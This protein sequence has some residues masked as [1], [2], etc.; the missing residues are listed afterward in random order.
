MAKSWSLDGSPGRLPDTHRPVPGASGRR[1]SLGGP[2]RGSG[3]LG[4]CWP[5]SVSGSVARGPRTRTDRA[6]DAPLRPRRPGGP[7]PHTDWAR[8]SPVHPRR[9]PAN[10]PPARIQC[11]P[12]ADPDP[13]DV[14]V[15]NRLCSRDSGCRLLPANGPHRHSAGQRRWRLIIVLVARASL[16]TV[17]AVPE[18]CRRQSGLAG[19][20]AGRPRRVGRVPGRGPPTDR[21]G[22]DG[23]PGRA[24]WSATSLLF[25]VRYPATRPVGR[26]ST[27][28]RR[29]STRSATTSGCPGH[30]CRPGRNEADDCFL[31]PGSPA[32]S[33]HGVRSARGYNPLDVARYRQFL[34]FVADVGEPQRAFSGNFTNPVMTDFPVKNRRLFD[35]LGV[36]WEVAPAD[37]PPAG[38]AGSGSSGTRRMRTP[39]VTTSSAAGCGN[40]AH[41]PVLQRAVDAAGVPRPRGRPRGGRGGRARAVEGH[42]PVADG[43]LAGWD[44]AADP[45]PAR[46]PAAAG[47]RRLPVRT[48]CT[49]NSTASRPGCS[50]SPTRGTPAGRA[51]ST[52]KRSRSGRPTTPSAECMVPK[53]AREVRVPVRAAIV[54][55]RSGRIARR[56][57][58]RRA[59]VRAHGRP[60]AGERR[61]VSDPIVCVVVRTGVARATPLAVRSPARS[62]PGR[63]RLAR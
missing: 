63:R 62:A 2:R 58:G 9:Q 22:P 36:A 12:N 57:G 53:G 31:G 39:G 38:A 16:R 45:L 33:V 19:V 41:A 29:C 49:S 23:R 50:W 30:S 20:L 51:G 17:R 47:S 21:P 37:D 43:D 5:W 55:G 8:S 27:R 13:I 15:P 40:S 52:G 56:G 4:P 54:P 18:A 61:R 34:A 28:G 59:S 35:L 14:R 48:G 3:S 7:G 25:S 60:T 10:R 46:P 26:R 32:A 6:Q 1:S 44:P 24:A 42:R 11:L